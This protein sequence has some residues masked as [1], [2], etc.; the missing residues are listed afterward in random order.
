MKQKPIWGGK[1]VLLSTGKLF[2]KKRVSKTEE[3]AEAQLKLGGGKSI[4]RNHAAEKHSENSQLIVTIDRS[5]QMFHRDTISDPTATSIPECDTISF[6]CV[7]I[8][9]Q[10]LTSLLTITDIIYMPTPSVK[11][12]RKWAGERN[13]S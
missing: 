11:W 13:H 4:Y 2:A 7:F 1:S 8:W 6:Y 5:H 12:A 3:E 10:S 9:S